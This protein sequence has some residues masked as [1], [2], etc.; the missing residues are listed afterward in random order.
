MQHS[1]AENQNPAVNIL[2]E[3]VLFIF[4]SAVDISSDSQ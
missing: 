4:F 3:K 1:T 2:V